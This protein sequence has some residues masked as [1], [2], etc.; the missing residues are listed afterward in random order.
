MLG[1]N[2]STTTL[3]YLLFSTKSRSLHLHSHE[4]SLS[5]WNHSR[6]KLF[7]FFYTNK[8]L[9]FLCF[10]ISIHIDSNICI[11]IQTYICSSFI[12]SYKHIDEEFWSLDKRHSSMPVDSE[13]FSFTCLLDHILSLCTSSS[14]TL[15]KP[16][17]SKPWA[18]W[19][20]RNLWVGELRWSFNCNLKFL[21]LLS[22]QSSESLTIY[23]KLNYWV[24]TGHFWLMMLHLID[25]L[26]SR[27]IL[28][29]FLLLILQHKFIHY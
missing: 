13:T 11:H 14:F 1:L 27:I 15:N 6:C 2:Q 10:S 28:Y 8:S 4:L 18:S 22:L 26:Q 23:C 19:R 12:Y 29:T 5:R 7:Y 9:F 24:H 21:L 16:Q 25:T 3:F 20:W 17:V